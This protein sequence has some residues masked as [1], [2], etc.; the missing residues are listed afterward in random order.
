MFI[1]NTVYTNLLNVFYSKHFM[2]D[3]VLFQSDN[4]QMINKHC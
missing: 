1:L 4:N 3:T 2:E